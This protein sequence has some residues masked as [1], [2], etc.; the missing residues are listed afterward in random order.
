MRIP[1]VLTAGDSATWLDDPFQ[2]AQSRLIGSS[3]YT[4]TYNLRGPTAAGL[5]LTAA[6]SGTGWTTS[7]TTV[8]SAA[9]NV[10]AANAIWFWQ[11]FA[12]K[13]GERISAGSGQI[14]VL[15]NLAAL[16]SATV[17]DGRTQNEIILA[18][19]RSEILARQTNGYA[20][21]YS[22]GSRSLKKEPMTG[23]LELES[24]YM[25]KVARERRARNAAN[26]LGKPGQLGV[27]FK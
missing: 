4:L 21:E 10:T 9:L 12:T 14:R 7:L 15:P 18:A 27:R 20:I 24:K 13:S 6:A 22:I 25:W 2:D 3:A 11:A 23:L 8:Q 19:I 17:Y 26:G 1:A 5:D 16:S